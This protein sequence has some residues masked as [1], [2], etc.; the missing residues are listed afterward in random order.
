MVR[1][2][3]YEVGLVFDLQK[4]Y[5]SMK[6]GL[7]EK[8]LR[9]LVC[10]FS[11]NDSW[12]DFGFATVA[13]GDIPAACFLELAKRMI[14]DAGAEL[15]P[16]ASRKLKQDSYVDDHITGGSLE[17][18]SRM[19]GVKS[20]SGAYS[21][22]VCQI[23]GKGNFKVKVMVQSGESDQEALDLLGNKV[24]GYYW[25]ASNDMMAVV[26]PVN[27]HG[28]VRKVNVKPDL[29]KAD[30]HLL[31]SVKLLFHHFLI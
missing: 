3:S 19:K 1:F 11:E 26:F 30:L 12:Q 10:R 15:D 20:E 6:T 27:L 7:V 16:M 25:D 14:A 29:T 21:G 28:K 24:L 18:V 13:F 22:T 17:K 8:H 4:A 5:N 31:H 23:L 2:R 9:K